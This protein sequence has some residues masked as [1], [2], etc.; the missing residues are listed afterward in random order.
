MKKL[1]D[2]P[3]KNP[4]N[5]PDDYFEKLPGKIQTRV[6]DTSRERSLFAGHAVRYALATITIAIIAFVWVLVT[7]NSSASES[8]E[9]I[10]ASLETSELIAYLN[11]GDIT[12]DELLDEI[13]LDAEDA[14][15]IEGA[16]F[17]LDLNDS[18]LNE[19][20]NEID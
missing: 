7:R 2:I 4:F 9:A 20:M 12:T 1:D 10:I 18:D 16:V 17:N 11:E 5:V 19:I 8:P 6:Q 3:K 14:L 13:N 15:E